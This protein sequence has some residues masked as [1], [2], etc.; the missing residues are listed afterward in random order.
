MYK[1]NYF[2]E[3]SRVAALYRFFE[4][5]QSMKEQTV[6]MRDI[7]VKSNRQYGDEGDIRILAKDIG[8]IGLLNPII[9]KKVNSEISE[10]FEIVAGRRRYA[11]AKI[12][13]WKE[14]KANILEAGEEENADAI[15]G[16]ENI[17][18]LAMHPL[19]E[20]L[21]FFK[22][23]ENGETTETLSKR[24]DRS[25]S[26]I[27]QR[28]SLLS[29]NDGI[30][31]FFRQGKIELHEAAMLKSLDEKQ[32]QAFLDKYS[33]KH[34]SIWEVKSF[35][36]S[37][38]HDKLFKC[39][40]GK[41]CAKC[42]KRTFYNDKALFPELKGEDDLCLDHECYM[43]KWDKLLSAK[44]KEVMLGNK[45]HAEAKEILCNADE[46]KKVFGKTVTVD[47]IEYAVIRTNWETKVDDKPS[48][49]AKPCFLISL[50]EIYGKGVEGDDDDDDDDD[51]D[52]VIDA[53]FDLKPMWWKEPVKKKETEQ[54]QPSPFEP[55]VSLL[56]IPEEEAKQTVSALKGNLKE[57]WEISLKA[58][59][60]NS[61]VKGKILHRLLEIIAK[62]QEQEEDI[63]RFLKYFIKHKADESS[64]KMVA[65]S[66]DVNALKK[67][68]TA[69]LFAALYASTFAAWN[70]PGIDDINAN[71]KHE[72]SVWAGVTTA[73]FKEMYKE[74]LMALMPKTKP[75]TP[76]KETAEKPVEGKKPE[77]KKLPSG[78]HIA[79]VKAEKAKPSVKKTTAKAKPAVRKP[80]A[81]KTAAKGKAKK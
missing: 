11:A 44:I 34:I 23:L 24:F 62:K 22:L 25:I 1:G 4:G 61:K 42:Q 29:L 80:V 38:Q 77:R 41:D 3:R 54:K 63:D 19:D 9:L 31:D 79:A 33:N 6:A 74:E 60:I 40:A 47:G 14:I 45:D 76:K 67:L 35:I 68:P 2:S 78:K 32:Q 70:L 13:G 12:L 52:E 49:T 18:R 7:I 56:E 5:E 75:V 48:K 30:K 50:K 43:K 15:A 10:S 26:A 65:G 39:I 71:K 69:K 72:L 55:M 57:S 59:D 17:N 37:V 51:E 46:L 27:W 66:I 81:K 64:L 21:I 53:K 36:S 16:S 73:Q 20:A 58:S 28:V 8:L